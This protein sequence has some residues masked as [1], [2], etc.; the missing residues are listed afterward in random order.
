MNKGKG[1]DD[2]KNKPQDPKGKGK[3]SK[4]GKPPDKSSK[5]CCYCGKEGHLQ[6]ERKEKKREVGGIEAQQPEATPTIGGVALIRQSAICG[7]IDSGYLVSIDSGSDADTCPVHIAR[8]GKLVSSSSSRLADIQGS[9]IKTF[10]EYD[11]TYLQGLRS[12]PKTTVGHTA[13]YSQQ[14]NQDRVESWFFG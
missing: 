9:D 11:V 8:L 5:K 12:V 3:S 4:D 13:P 7:S 10:G 6:S 1:T 14:R 2:G